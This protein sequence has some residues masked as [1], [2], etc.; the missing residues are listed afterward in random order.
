MQ[1]YC[2]RQ[3]FFLL[4][5]NV[6]KFFVRQIQGKIFEKYFGGTAWVQFLVF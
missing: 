1:N 4:G 3:S 6:T 5:I 2:A